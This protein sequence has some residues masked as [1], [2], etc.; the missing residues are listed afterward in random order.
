MEIQQI[1]SAIFGSLTN[2]IAVIYSIAHLSSNLDNLTQKF[3]YFAP[4][5]AENNSKTFIEALEKAMRDFTNIITE[6]FS[7][8]F[9][10]LS[11]TVGELLT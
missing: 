7:K 6:L 5:G 8:N 3:E 11:C 2:I 9:K 1:F 10:E 4:I